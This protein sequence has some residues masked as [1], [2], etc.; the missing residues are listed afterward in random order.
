MPERAPPLLFFRYDG[1]GD[2]AG[3]PKDKKERPDFK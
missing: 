2:R 3:I 1:E